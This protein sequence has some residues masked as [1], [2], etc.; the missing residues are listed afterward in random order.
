MDYSTKLVF[1]L[2]YLQLKSSIHT[3]KG[4]SGTL[5]I[6]RVAKVATEFDE[7]I[8]TENYANVNELLDELKKT[9]NEFLIYYK[10]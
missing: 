1:Y 3:I 9:F 6:N 2:N 7:Q 8:K 4:S 5:G 10:V